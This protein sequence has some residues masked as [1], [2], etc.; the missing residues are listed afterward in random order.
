M[1]GEGCNVRG[2]PTVPDYG[3]RDTGYGIGAGA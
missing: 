3:I 1:E 2:V